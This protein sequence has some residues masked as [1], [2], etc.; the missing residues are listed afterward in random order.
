LNDLITTRRDFLKLTGTA[1]L[2]VLTAGQLARPVSA[3]SSMPVEQ[4]SYDSSRDPE[5]M[6]LFLCGDVMTGR[7]IDQ[8]L[9]YHN[10]PRLY[11]PYVT[12]AQVYVE[13]A[14]QMNGPIPAPVGFSY[15]WGD[16]LTEFQRVM[17]DVRIIN[18][19]T[20][21]TTSEDHW[22]AKGIHYRMHPANVPCLTAARIDCCVLA[23]NH[24]LDWGYKG[25]VDTLQAL[26]KA[27]MRT[28]GAG[29]NLEA[30]RTPAVVEARGKGKVLVFAFG[31]ES[32]GIP[33]DWAAAEKGPGVDLLQDLSPKTVQRI[34]DQ[35]WTVKRARDVVVASIHWGSNWGYGI[36]REQQVFAHRLIDEAGVD[37]VHGHS[38]HHPKGIEVYKDKPILYGCGDFLNDYEG[39]SGY[40]EFRDDLV[41]MYFVT[42]SPLSGRLA[43]LEM[44]P[45]QIKRFRLNRPSV[46]DIRWLE[47]T[48]DRESRKLGAAVELTEE[49]HLRL[50]W[51]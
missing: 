24:V 29:Q 43:R 10:N 9:P 28:A 23:N 25:L 7:G 13:I 40:E 32:S 47:R 16:A 33:P 38:S 8:V 17:P 22:K 34:A 1:A 48:L 50:R 20:A 21:V 15:V 19:E 36:P 35:V 27:N 45:M 2:E 44:I 4:T 14:E 26:E 6:T 30:V 5:S 3:R 51:E 31:C 49:N 41:L 18:L 11:E 37:V 46:A 42:L 39:I 12:T